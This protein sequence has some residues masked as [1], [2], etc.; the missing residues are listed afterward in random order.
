MEFYESTYFI[1]LV[2]SVV[3]TVIFLFFWLFMKETSYDEILAKQKKDLKLPPAKID[4]KKTDKKKNK[5]KESQN[6]NLQESDSETAIRDFDLGDAL[7]NEEE[8]VV[9]TPVVVAEPAVNIR[10]RKKK[11]KKQPKPAVED[12]VGKEI[13]GTKVPSKKPETVPV[14]KQATPPPDASGSKKKQGS[15]KQKNGQDIKHEQIVPSSKKQETPISPVEVKPQESGS[16]KKKASAKK[17]KVETPLVDEPLIQPTVYIPLMDN[18]EPV[19]AEKKAERKESATV[20]KAEVADGPQKGSGKKIKTVTDKENAE[21]KFKDFLMTMKSM[22][23]SEDEVMSVVEMLK[24]KSRTV[25]EIIHKANKGDSAALHMLREKDKQLV[26]AREET[27]GVK[28]QYKHITQELLAEKQK[29]SIVEAKARERITAVEKE[30]NVFQSK[31]HSSYQET[32]QMQLKREDT[33]LVLASAPREAHASGLASVPQRSHASGSR[34]RPQRSHASGS[35][36]LPQRSPRFWFSPPPPEKPRFWF[37]PPPPEKPR[38]WFLPPPPEEATLLVLASAPE[39]PHFWFSPPPPEKAQIQDAERR[40]EEVETYLRNRLAE[41]DGTQKDMQAKL[42]AKESEVQ[43]LHS[44]LTDTMVSNQQLEQRILQMMEAAG[45]DQSLQ[46]QVQS[47]ASVL[48]EELQKTITEKDKEIKQMESSLALGRANF[49][50][51]GEELKTIQRENLSLKADL[52]KLQGLKNEQVNA[53]QAFEQLQKSIAEKEEKIRRLEEQ[54]HGEIAKVSSNMEDYT[55]NQELLGQM[56]MSM[57]EKDEKIKTVEELLETGLIQ[58]ANK[59][60][61]LRIL[62]DEN[63]SLRMD[64][65]NVKAQQTNQ[66]SLSSVV[67][68]LKNVIHEKDGKIKSVEDLLHAEHLRADNQEKIVQALNKEVDA[69]QETI[70]AYQ[71]ETAEQVSSAAQVQELQNELKGKEETLKVIE[72]KYRERENDIANKERQLADLDRECKLLKAHIEEIQNLQQVLR[73][74]HESLKVHASELQQQRDHQTQQYEANLMSGV[75]VLGPSWKTVGLKDSRPTQKLLNS[76][77]ASSENQQHVHAAETEARAILQKLFPNV[78]VSASLRH[79]EWIQE[80]EKLA[81]VSLNENAGE[82][83]VKAVEQKLREGEEIHSMLQLECEKYKSVLAETEGILQRLQR[84]VEEEEGRWKIK[85]EESQMELKEVCTRA[86]LTLW[87]VH[88]LEQEVEKLKSRERESQSLLKERQHLETELEKAEVERAT[89]VSEVRELKELL[90]ELQR[91]LDGSKSEAIRQN[92]ELTLLKTRLNDTLQ[93]LEGEQNERQ[94]VASDLHEGQFGSVFSVNPELS[95]FLFML[96]ECSSQ[97]QKLLDLIQLEI[98][99]AAGGESNVIENSG[100]SSETEG[101]ERKEKVLLSLSQ[102]VTRLQQCLQAVNQQ[103]TKEQFQI[104][105]LFPSTLVPTLVCPGR[106]CPRWVARYVGARAG[107][108]GQRLNEFRFIQSPFLNTSGSHEVFLADR[109][110]GI[111]LQLLGIFCLPTIAA[112]R[113]LGTTKLYSYYLYGLPVSITYTT[114]MSLEGDEEL[115]L[116]ATPT[117]VETP[118]RRG[119]I[120]SP[121]SIRSWTIPRITTELRRRQIPYPA[122]ARKAELFKLLNNSTDNTEAGEGPSNTSSGDIQAMLASLMTSMGKVNDRLA[123]LEAVTTALSK[124]GLPDAAQQAPSEPRAAGMVIS[125][126]YQD[127]DP[128]YTIPAHIKRDILEGKDVNLAS[129][130]IASQDVVENKTYMYD[131]VSVVVRS[132]DVRLNRKLTIPEFVLAFGIFR[133]YGRFHSS[134]SRGVGEDRELLPTQKPP[135][136]FNLLFQN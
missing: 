113:V 82:E 29:S 49:T 11:D 107:T 16:G 5:K 26:A 1:I 10:E 21:V 81:K 103:L 22:I 136:A 17:Q 95:Y 27:A 57:Q 3:I 25:Q 134:S 106:W 28:E 19:G 2:P 123:N 121:A 118:S 24:E 112:D 130:L 6:G 125:S 87:C 73:S 93:E 88:S 120:A 53:A 50:N 41:F 79:G 108:P 65:Q 20:E 94:K 12:T 55:T 40:V 76:K 45:Q 35:R 4:K 39:K 54:L 8:H 34:L 126:D 101:Q 60:E 64:L 7:S 14:V 33:L 75:I 114:S 58:V 47:S 102:S 30:H 85:V 70:K 92:E 37:S 52:Q 97:A 135:H 80:F 89:Y 124:A 15:K 71:H 51:T 129:L 78:S 96:L 68:D 122:T 105:A 43:S 117:R 59:E 67:E 46:M 63:E 110:P 48:V 32:Q 13:N 74:E 131:D 72:V 111:L 99:R 133:D 23:L 42:L 109:C 38:F 36:L 69:L 132:K 128:A 86:L 62:R 44:K 83:K 18:T 90:T 61:E 115:F 127:V 119:D 84:S 98:L 77:I 104:I 116:H 31:M 91:K 100:I 9:P 56:E 66:I